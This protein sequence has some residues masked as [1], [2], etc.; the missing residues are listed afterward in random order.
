M[1][2]PAPR[3]KGVLVSGFPSPRLDERAVSSPE[4]LERLRW[5]QYEIDVDPAV[6]HES[7]DRFEEELTRVFTRRRKTVL[8][9]LEGEPWDLF[10]AHVME[11]DRL[12][13]FMWQYLSE[14]GSARGQFVLDFLSQV[15]RFVGEV[16]ERVDRKAE[17]LVM[18]DHGFCALKYETQVNRWLRQQGWLDHADA[19]ERM[20]K[21]VKPGSRAVSLVPGRIHLL[22][23]FFWERG[24]VGDIEARGLRDEIVAALRRWKHPETGEAVCARVMTREE[25]FQGHYTD[26]APDI[27]IDPTDGYDLKAKLGEGDLFEKDT[28]SG[29]HTFGD[30]MLLTGKGLGEV[31]EAGEVAEVGAAVAGTVL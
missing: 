6:A 9:L 7:L 8:D 21:A 11:T 27:I 30:A 22:T 3:L 1:T 23:K 18:S 15:D 14:P 16:A 28:L 10:F 2:W 19:P 13:H 24:T 29:M 17:L 20:F 25:A 26:R 4:I 5:T 31:A 12:Y